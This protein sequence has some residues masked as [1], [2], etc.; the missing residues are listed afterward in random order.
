[1]GWHAGLKR[2][3]R[4]ATMLRCARSCPPTMFAPP[5]TPSLPPPPP[6]PRPNCPVCVPHLLPLLLLLLLCTPPLLPQR[7]ERL[8]KTGVAC[9]DGAGLSA[10]EPNAYR[11]R[12][13]KRVVGLVFRRGSRV[14]ASSALVHAHTSSSVSL[15]RGR[16]GNGGSFGVAPAAAGSL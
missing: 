14:R 6:C 13:N 12:F 1:M 15:P 3:F 8:L 11:L 7:M 16:S 9:V 4:S 10:L 5:T 2:W